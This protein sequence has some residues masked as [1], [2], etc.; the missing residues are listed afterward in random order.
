MAITDAS[1]TILDLSIGA[2][3]GSLEDTQIAIEHGERMEEGEE[4]REV[5]TNEQEEAEGED[6]VEGEEVVE[7]I[8]EDGGDTQGVEDQVDAGQ[9][10]A[11]FVSVDGATRL[12]AISLTVHG[13]IVPQKVVE[14]R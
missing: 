6:E 8:G 3:M 11:S 5:D 2:S 10:H 12:V 9:S 14:D 7:T 1:I 13:A 4:M